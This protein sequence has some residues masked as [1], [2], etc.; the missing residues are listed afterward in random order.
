MHRC[1]FALFLSTLNPSLS[2]AV[3]VWARVRYGVNNVAARGDLDWVFVS[4]DAFLYQMCWF[5]F[6]IEWQLARAAR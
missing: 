3:K 5:G 6:L 4:W 2:L 1:A